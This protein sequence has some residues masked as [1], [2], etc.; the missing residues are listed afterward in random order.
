MGPLSHDQPWGDREPGTRTGMIRLFPPSH[1][2]WG[3][4]YIA[5]FGAD[6]GLMRVLIYAWYS[7]LKEGDLMKTVIA[8]TSVVNLAFG[9]FVV[10]LYLATASPTLVLLLGLGLI[11]QGGYT[12]AYLTGW[13]NRSEPWTRHVLLAGSTLALL[14][15]LGGLLTSVTNT[16]VHSGPGADPEYG[17]IAVAGLIAAH[18]AA[19]L[20]SYAWATTAETGRNRP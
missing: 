4:D 10:V 16:I 14:V 8:T 6:R 19:V 5:E 15:G 13:L 7:A 20:I 9:G 12:L 3:E 17:P 1:R 11:V 2:E 18:A